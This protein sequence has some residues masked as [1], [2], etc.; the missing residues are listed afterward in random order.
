M[1]KMYKW[2]MQQVL[3]A[4]VLSTQGKHGEVISIVESIHNRI[5]RQPQ[6]SDM[7]SSPYGKLLQW[8][9]NFTSGDEETDG[10]GLKAI[11]DELKMAVDIETNRMANEKAVSYQ[12]FMKHAVSHK[13]GQIFHRIL[14]QKYG[15]YGNTC[16]QGETRDYGGS[17]SC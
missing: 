15:N 1:V 7:L 17:A 11:Y 9:E 13:N 6:F 14:R 2:A 3:Q 4:S 5:E 12:R 10:S 8:S 16:L